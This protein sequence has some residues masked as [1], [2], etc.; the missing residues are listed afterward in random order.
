MTTRAIASLD[1]QSQLGGYDDDDE[2]TEV[3]DHVTE[4]D[5]AVDSSTNVLLTAS[6]SSPVY[7]R[8]F[9]VGC[10]AG[11]SNNQQPQQTG[12]ELRKRFRNLSGTAGS[13]DRGGQRQQRLRSPAPVDE[14]LCPECQSSSAM[15]HGK[16][17]EFIT[18]EFILH[19]VNL[20]FV[21]FQIKVSNAYGNVCN[22]CFPAH[23]VRALTSGPAH[24]VP[25]VK[26]YDRA[27][28]VEVLLLNRLFSLMLPQ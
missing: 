4:M 28:V 23:L 5:D 11:G 24:L 7:Q 27:S 9:S 18:E 15:R 12:V 16:L 26:C 3:F 8:S 1:S 25:H 10:S 13:S 17:D 22:R 2:L 6:A 20:F 14:K 21:Y 19:F